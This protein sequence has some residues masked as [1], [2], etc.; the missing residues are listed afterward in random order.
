MKGCGNLIRLMAKASSYILMEIFTMANGKIIR[1][2]ALED[3]K[4]KQVVIMKEDGKEMNHMGS[5]FNNGEMVEHESR[6]PTF[7]SKWPIC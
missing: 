6:E 1:L 5:E 3:M 2:R 4:E 7:C